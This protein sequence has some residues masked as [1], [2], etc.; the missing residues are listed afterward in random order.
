M[1]TYRIGPIR[2]PSEAQSLLLQITQGCTWNKC[3]FCNL[4][5]GMQFKTFSAESIKQDIDNIL[6]RF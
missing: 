5:R 2:P 4:Y 1:G 6:E 3:K